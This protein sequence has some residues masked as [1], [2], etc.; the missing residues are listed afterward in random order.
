VD[1]WI[2]IDTDRTI[3]M[4][5]SSSYASRQYWDIPRFLDCA[6]ACARGRARAFDTHFLDKI[7]ITIS[8]LTSSLHL[9]CSDIKAPDVVPA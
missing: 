7:K 1:D 4:R 8:F 2:I 3:L 6:D 9:L 5:R